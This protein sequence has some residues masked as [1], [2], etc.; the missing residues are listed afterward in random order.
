MKHDR[1]A[2]LE[3]GVA[4]CCSP[5]PMVHRPVRLVLL[6]APGVG[7]GTQ[8]ELLTERLGACHLSTGDVFRTAKQHSNGELSPV[9]AAALEHMKRGELVPDETVLAIL[10]E[11]SRC[12]HCRG[13]FLLDGFPR[14]VAQAEALQKTLRELGVALDAVVSYELPLE[15]VAERICGRRTCARCHA[16]YHLEALRPK[17]AD[18]CDTCGGPLTQREDDHPEPVRVRLAAHQKSTAPLVEY[19]RH[20]NL[21]LPV[22]V[23]SVPEVTFERT[24]AALREWSTT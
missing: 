17:V 22:A 9:M 13:G 23:G 5:P 21:L 4:T 10:R 2:W 3:G 15:Q 11:R 16:I 8:A 19:Y 6:G 20:L 14:T 1:A 18:I 24:I 12:L 7:K